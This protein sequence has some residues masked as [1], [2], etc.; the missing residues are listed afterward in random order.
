MLDENYGL[1]INPQIP[2]L[3]TPLN[4]M[5]KMIDSSDNRPI[6]DLDNTIYAS[7]YGPNFKINEHG[8]AETTSANI[9]YKIWSVA[10][11]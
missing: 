7:K 8:N 2:S 5:D 4:T 9:V 10:S 6:Q 3:D 11:D 1:G